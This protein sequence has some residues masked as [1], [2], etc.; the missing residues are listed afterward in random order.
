[1]IPVRPSTAHGSVETDGVRPP[2]AAEPFYLAAAN[3]IE[4]FTACHER[5]LP[6]MLKGPT[7]CGKTRFV[8]HMAWRLRRPL[9]TVACHD[10]LSASDLVGR[11]LVQGNETVWQDGPLTRAV[12]AGALCY[13]DEV[14]EARQDT[15]V[16]IHPLTDDR[17]VLPIDKTGELVPAAPGFHLVVSYNPGYQHLLKDLKPSTRQRFVALEFAIPPAEREAAIVGARGR[18]RP[19][20]SH[21][22]GDA[23]RAAAPA[24]RPGARE[25]PSTRLLVAAARLIASGVPPRDAC[26][27]AIAAPLTTTLISWPRLDVIAATLSRADGRAGRPHHRGSPARDRRGPRPVVAHPAARRAAELALI[28]VRARLELLLRALFGE[29][30]A[31]L[32][33]DPDRVPTW[34]ARLLTRAR[35]I[36][37][38]ERRSRRRTASACGSPD[39]RRARGRGRRARPLP[40]ARDRAGGPRRPRL[41]CPA[42]GGRG[43]PE[44]DLHR[45]ATA[46]AVD[47]ALAGMPRRAR[48]WRLRAG[49]PVRRPPRAR[50]VPPRSPSS[51]AAVGA[52]REPAAP[53]VALA[54]VRPPGDARDWASAEARRLE[55]DTA[56]AGWPP[57]PSGA[58]HD[59]PWRRRDRGRARRPG[60]HRPPDARPPSGGA[61]RATRGGRRGRRDARHVDG[62]VDDPMESAEDPMGSSARP[63]RTDRPSRRAGGRARR[64]PRGAGGPRVRHPARAPRERGARGRGGLDR[65]RHRRATSGH[66]VPRMGLPPRRVPLFGRHRPPGGGGPGRGGLGRARLERHHALVRGV[67]RR[68]DGLRRAAGCSAA[69][70]TATT[71]ICSRASA[72]SRIAGPARPPTIGCTPRRGR[73]SRPGHRGAGRRERVDRRLGRRRPPHRGRGEGGAGR[74]ARGARRPG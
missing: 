3:E 55:T 64:S 47:R 56:I 32:P 48:G 49:T 25:V 62:R 39:A 19:P 73:T 4:V 23:G 35:L 6:V 30:F 68:F 43:A 70:S 50:S 44:R 51:E 31:I 24:P 69:S 11:Y 61:A 29:A 16:V 13:L 46:V 65:I 2:P 1:M 74:A 34:L 5:G 7:G 9:V 20:A 15:I 37:G 53:P 59:L 22:A 14:V 71:S 10:D 21:R 17:R 12:R 8:E 72:P 28:R 63:T 38:G 52:G 36:S 58:S 41:R 42:P 18:R 57:S 60:R 27:V 33:A 45:L 54:G 40:P 26:R 67:R 66:R